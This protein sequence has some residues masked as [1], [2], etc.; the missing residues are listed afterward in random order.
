MAR[1]LARKVVLL[2]LCAAVLVLSIL[3]GTMV[4]ALLMRAQD[5]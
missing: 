1:I 3:T 5:L 4:S 2:L